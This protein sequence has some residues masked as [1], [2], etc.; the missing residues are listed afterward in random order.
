ML[1]PTAEFTATEVVLVVVSL[2][3]GGGPSSGF[4]CEG[5]SVLLHLMVGRFLALWLCGSLALSSCSIRMVA[6][7]RE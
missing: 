1:F 5:S 2:L 7:G 6:L 4:S 3:F